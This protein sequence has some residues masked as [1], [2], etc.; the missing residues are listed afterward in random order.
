MWFKNLVLYRLTEPFE[1][2]PEQLSAALARQAAKPCGGL[3]PFSFGFSPPLGRLGKELVHAANGCTLLCARKEERLLPGSVVKET[4]EERIAEIEMRDDR[5]VRGKERKRMRDDVIFELMPKAFTRSTYTFAYLSPKDGWLIVDAANTK[6]AEELVV[7]LGTAL[8]RFEVEQLTAQV[9]PV[10]I[11]TR[12]LETQSLPQGFTLEQDCELR[13]PA[14]EGAVVRCQRQDLASDE[15]KAHLR[16]RKQAQRLALGLEARLSFVLCADLT[17]KRLRFEAVE[18]L[19]E[20]DEADELARFDANF[21]FMT[22][23][24]A[25]LSARL[26]EVFEVSDPASG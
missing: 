7:L 9:S 17:V 3:E 25:R 1:H 21:A 14:D 18:E 6:R 26:G 13:D 22:T 23:E 15:I 8:R 16:A 10:S 19:D 4:L 20:V 5:R 2:T 24:L 12:W 11:M